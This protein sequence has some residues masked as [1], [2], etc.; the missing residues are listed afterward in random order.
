DDMVTCDDASGDGQEEFDLESQTAGV[1]GALN[2]TDFAVTYHL[3]LADAQA[4]TG[5]LSSP[6]TNTDNPQTI[7]VRVE[8]VNAVGLTTGCFATTSFDLVIS[9]P[10][11][12]AVSENIVVCD[13]DSNDGVEAFDLEAHNSIV[14]DGQDDTQFTVS[15][16]ASEA[17]ANAGDNPLA[18][19][20][21][22]DDSPGT[23]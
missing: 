23:Q 22:N 1:L 20:H 9:G 5:A 11:P 6:F 3:S 7:F 14:L 12:N 21:T 15:Y 19:P 16:Y 2:P 8:D 10:T 13:D 4:G 18:S 17:D